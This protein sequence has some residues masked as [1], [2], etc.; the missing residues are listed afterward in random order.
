MAATK[1][2]NWLIALRAPQL[3]GARLVRL[4]E[5]LGG[6]DQLAAASRG[7]L[8]HA[9]LHEEAIHAVLHPDLAQLEKDLKWLSE[10]THDLLTWENEQFPALLRNIPSPPAA[11]FVDGDPDIL[12]HPQVAV[13]G[14]R[15]PTA[16]GKD[17]ARDFSGEL[18][19]RGMTVTS[20]LAAGI[21]SISHAAALDTGGTTVAVMGTGLDRIYPASSRNLAERI[22][23]KG[24]LVSEFALGTGAKRSNFP[25]R[26]RIIS[27]LSLGVLVIEAGLRSGTLITARL[28]GNQG[29]DVFALPGSIHNPMAKGCHRLIRDGARLIESVEEIMQE[30]AP[31]A[32]QLAAELQKQIDFGEESPMSLP[33][34]NKPEDP[35]VEQDPDYQV[36]WSCLGFDPKPID[37][38]IE[39]SGLTASAV[40][41][42]LLLLELRGKVEVHSGG[43]Y[44]RKTR[45]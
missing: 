28:A 3:G 4:M 11:L 16:G 9:G 29:R 39:Q 5:Q 43:A 25:A 21:D 44:S 22:R 27:G 2:R 8:K 41:A 13:I 20:G 23:A 6:S 7:D 32:G 38:I 33:L 19:R 10:P 30:L 34:E 18:T 36:L 31:M 12:W 40:S 17:N 1:Q 15:N 45:G 37:T 42:M 24:V 26:N 14:S 35:Q